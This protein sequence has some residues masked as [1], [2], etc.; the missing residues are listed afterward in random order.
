M[1]KRTR[2]ATAMGACALC[3]VM[4]GGAAYALAPSYEE[5][6][7]EAAAEEAAADDA[8][9]EAFS[10]AYQNSAKA[11]ELCGMD[12]DGRL[13]SFPSGSPSIQGAAQQVA[14]IQAAAEAATP[15]SST[16]SGTTADAAVAD[17]GA[18]KTVPAD[19]LVIFGNVIPYVDAYS[20]TTAPADSAGLWMG[21]D[22]TNDG[23]W[24]YFIGHHPGVFNCVMYLGEGDAIT[25]CDAD[26]NARTYTVF[27]VYDVADDTTWSQISS[28]VTSHGES[29]ALQTCN[30]DH[31]TYRIVEAA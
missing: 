13:I 26:G 28:E 24:G 19:S 29:I 6:Q 20:A 30:G 12:A 15:A 9:A 21:S 7:E 17:T 10:N 31:A 23:S 14:V 22:S 18:P 2:I 11:L 27:A 25:V 8:A 4:A 1:R 16:A 3:A 5:A